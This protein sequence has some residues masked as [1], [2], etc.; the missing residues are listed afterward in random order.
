M[1]NLAI[2]QVLCNESRTLA[3][4]GW[5]V[6]KDPW[7][8]SLSLCTA[9]K[10]IQNREQK[11]GKENKIEHPYGCMHPV[12]VVV[13]TASVHPSDRVKQRGYIQ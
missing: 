3:A 10:L 11:H 2:M 4:H 13:C 8:Y 12:S 1:P 7:G 5:H 9:I 6:T